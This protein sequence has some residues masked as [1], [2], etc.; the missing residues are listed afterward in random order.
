M[1]LQ[2]AGE[3]NL[4]LSFEFWFKPVCKHPGAAGTFGQVRSGDCQIFAVR[5]EVDG[6]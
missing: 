3:D 4:A 2:P 1:Y 6:A 5:S